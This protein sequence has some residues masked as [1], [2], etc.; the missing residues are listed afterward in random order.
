MNSFEVEGRKRKAA[1][2]AVALNDQGITSRD[3]R[4]ATEE[5]WELAA[6]MAV[7]LNP[8]G[9]KWKIPS[10]ETRSLTMRRMVEIETMALPVRLLPNGWWF[11]SPDNKHFGPYEDQS[12]A[13]QCQE[14]AA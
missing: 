3:M 2:L 13:Q 12:A 14:C 4:G 8:D 5:H 7:E 10:P 6:K 9:K 1:V 11:V